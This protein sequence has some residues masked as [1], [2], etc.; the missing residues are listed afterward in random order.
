M[1]LMRSLAAMTGATL[2]CGSALA[3]AIAVPLPE[4]VAKADFIGVVEI[5]SVWRTTVPEPGEMDVAPEGYLQNADG[6]VLEVIKGERVP[7]HVVINFD[8]GFVCPN[9]LYERGAA[10]LV[11]LHEDPDGRYSTVGYTQGRFKVRDDLIDYWGR[12]DVVTLSNAKQD[13]QRLMAR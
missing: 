13:I 5:R 9:V 10:Y 1:R 3:L 2:A 12:Q 4:R 7:S 8:T 6:Y 11:F